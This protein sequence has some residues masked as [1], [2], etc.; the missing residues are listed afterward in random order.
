VALIRWDPFAELGPFREDLGRLFDRYSSLIGMR[1]WQPAV[2]LCE[3]DD[4]FTLKAEIPGVEP[5]NVDITVTPENIT[6]RGTVDREEEEQEEGY[7]RSERRYGEF[8][9]TVALPAEIKPG[10]ARATF[11]N[12]VLTVVLP[13]AAPGHSRGVKLKIDRLQ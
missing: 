10:T 5:E 7:I 12:G 13:K 3:D 2:D 4:T 1:G 8:A 9:R 11:K 6:L